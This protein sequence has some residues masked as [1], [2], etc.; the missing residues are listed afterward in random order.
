MTSLTLVS[1]IPLPKGFEPSELENIHQFITDE[2]DPAISETYTPKQHDADL[3]EPF[4]NEMFCAKFLN[5]GR[6]S[7]YISLASTNLSTNLSNCSESPMFKRSDSFQDRVKRCSMPMPGEQSPPSSGILP[8]DIT[9]RSGLF[10]DSCFEDQ[11]RKANRAQGTKR[12]NKDKDVKKTTNKDMEYE[13]LI[14]ILDT[15]DKLSNFTFSNENTTATHHSSKRFSTI[16]TKQPLPQNR[17]SKFSVRIEE[18]N[19]AHPMLYVGIITS[20][21]K[22]RGLGYKP[23]CYFISTF[24]QQAYLSRLKSIETSAFAKKGQVISVFTDL[25]RGR[26]SFE[27]EGNKVLE[28]KVNIPRGKEQEFYPCVCLGELGG[29]VSFI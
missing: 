20:D 21:L 23:G 19:K 8:E 28:G 10:K 1:N 26:I 3:T 6:D 7:I 9:P 11:M 18:S 25:N 15:G 12:S 16:V 29:K 24:S 22:D 2:K 13:H 4:Q 14:P 27:I 5:P 17:K